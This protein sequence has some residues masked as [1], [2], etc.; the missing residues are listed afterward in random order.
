MKK[1]KLSDLKIG[2]K[3]IIKL[4]GRPSELEVRKR[5]DKLE[6]KKH[7]VTWQP[8]EE[9]QEEYQDYKDYLKYMV[10]K[11]NIYIK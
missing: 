5:L 10:N 4:G 3:F 11:G 6:L 8:K 9:T 1:A 7:K 2:T